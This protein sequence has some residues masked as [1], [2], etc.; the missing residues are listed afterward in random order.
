MG[1]GKKLLSL[2]HWRKGP[3]INYVTMIL[4]IF[5]H[6]YPHVRICKIFLTPPPYSYIRFHFIFQHNKMLLEKDNLH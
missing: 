2:P 3:F 1:P 4:A 5:D 6:T